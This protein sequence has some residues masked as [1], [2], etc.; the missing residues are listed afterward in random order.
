MSPRS[1]NELSFSSTGELIRRKPKT[2]KEHATLLEKYI[3]S[4]IRSEEGGLESG[5]QTPLVAPSA[6]ALVNATSAKV[7]NVDKKH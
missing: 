5:A 7:I 6:V 3:L 1:P 4:E 2:L